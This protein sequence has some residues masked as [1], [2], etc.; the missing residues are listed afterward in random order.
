MAINP[1]IERFPRLWSFAIA[2][3]FSHPNGQPFAWRKNRSEEI[4]HVMR[5]GIG[6]LA[7]T[8]FT[9][10]KNP[11]SIVAMTALGSLAVT[12][13]FYPETTLNF[14]ATVCPIALKIE[15]WMIRAALYI[16][17]QTTV[18]GL[19]IRTLGRLDNPELVNNWKAGN[20]VPVYPG[21]RA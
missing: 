14:I 4:G 16:L 5:M 7:N 3:D 11:T 8:F 20:L 12:M 13:A 15:A 10:I 1:N 9:H 2:K 17:C 21:D 18:L 6:S 19:C